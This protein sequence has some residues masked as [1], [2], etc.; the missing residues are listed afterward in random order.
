M[1]ITIEQIN[2]G[3]IIETETVKW[4][5]S[6]F[7]KVLTTL[8]GKMGKHILPV[9][10]TE[11]KLGLTGVSFGELPRQEV[12]DAHSDQP[13]RRSKTPKARRNRIHSELSNKI[14]LDRTI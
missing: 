3:Y 10:R 8:Q 7:L 4:H 9:L 13:K 2:N 12:I 14:A 6:E 1:K 11:D 5:E